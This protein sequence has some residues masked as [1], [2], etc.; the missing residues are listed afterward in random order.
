MLRLGGG[1]MKIIFFFNVFYMRN[2]ANGNS[3]L[4]LLPSEIKF[5]ERLQTKKIAPKKIIVKPDKLRVTSFF[6][7]IMQKKNVKHL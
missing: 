1:G 7:D 2:F 4:L 3:L 5:L 6:R